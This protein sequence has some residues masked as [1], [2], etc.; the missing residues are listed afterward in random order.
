[1][2]E[3]ER[4]DAFAHRAGMTGDDAT[5]LEGLDVVRTEPHGDAHAG[6]AHGHRVEALAHAD[7]TLRIH[8]AAEEEPGVERL[9]R[10]RT[11]HGPFEGEML[12]DGHA[13]AVDAPDVVEAVTLGDQLVELGDGGDLGHG[14]HVATAEP[15]DLAFDPTLFVRSVLAGLAV[16]GIEEVVAAQRDEALGL[17]AVAAHQHPG[18]GGLQI[19]VADAL[20]VPPKC[21]KAR[22]CPSMK[23]S[24]AWL[25]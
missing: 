23:D 15:A 10:K 17:E 6:I 9:G 1:M 3:Y 24:W 13:P 14:H 4:L 25:A 16:E 8:P 11:Q 21:S 5:S 18:D 19:V 2:V 7:S 22:S 12:G 20:G